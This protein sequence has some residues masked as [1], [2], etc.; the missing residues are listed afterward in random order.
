[1]YYNFKMTYVAY[2]EKKKKKR[3]IAYQAAAA[4]DI[5]ISY[6][7]SYRKSSIKLPG[8]LFISNPF[9]RRGLFVLEKT[10]VSVLHKK[11]KIQSGKAQV[12]EV[13]GHAAEDQKEIRT[14][15]W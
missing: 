12:Q 1:M 6:I 5:T 11:T 7:F 4:R 9:G 10:M 13:G 2:L 14:S 8:G 3:L 15:S